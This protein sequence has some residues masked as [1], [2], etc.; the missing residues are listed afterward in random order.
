MYVYTENVWNVV[1]I[2]LT[3]FIQSSKAVLHGHTHLWTKLW[4][5]THE[6]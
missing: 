4:V 2:L 5:Q 6:M 3:L 1:C